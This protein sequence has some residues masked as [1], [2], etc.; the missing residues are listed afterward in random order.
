MHRVCDHALESASALTQ[1]ASCQGQS[2]WVECSGW[3]G[4]KGVSHKGGFEAT[5]QPSANPWNIF[6]LPSKRGDFASAS[7]E[8]AQTPGLN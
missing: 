5:H 1:G 2:T 4:T 3:Q 7:H 8:I 6:D